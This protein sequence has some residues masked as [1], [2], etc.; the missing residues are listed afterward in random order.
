MRL[1]LSVWEPYKGL[2]LFSET[3]Q[4]IFDDTAKTLSGF[5]IEDL[6]TGSWAPRVDIYETKDSYIVSAD[7]PGIKKEDIGIDLKDNILTVRGEKKFEEKSDKDNYVR[8]ERKY[9]KFV[10]RFG[11]SDN[12][13]AGKIKASYKDGV[14]EIKIPKREEATTKPV[15]VEVN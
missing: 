13:E 12:V 4:K 1:G 7:L 8:V 5:G 14:L 11:L 3:F 6:G 2:N 10:R 9:G 15:R